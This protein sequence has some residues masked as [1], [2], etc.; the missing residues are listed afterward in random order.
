MSRCVD[1]EMFRTVHTFF[2]PPPSL[3]QTSPDSQNR[4][5]ISLA[6][7]VSLARQAQ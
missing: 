4:I 1:I 2:S 3:V 6:K 7:K 5:N